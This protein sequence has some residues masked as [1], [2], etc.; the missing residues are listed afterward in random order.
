VVPPDQLQIIVSNIGITTDFSAIYTPNSAPHTAFVQVSLKVGHKVGSYEYMRRVRQQ[1]RQEL[2]QL[3]TYFQ[4]G[5]L[6]DAVINL[7]LPAPID[8]QVSGNNLDKVYEVATKIAGPVRALKSVNDVLIPQDIDYPALELDVDRQKAGLL[9]LSQKEIV[10]NVI[11]ALTSNGMIAPNYW[12]D[13]KSGNPYLLTVQYPEGAVK[14]MTDLKQIP[15]RG[16]KSTQPTSLDTVVKVKTIPSPTEVDHYQLFRVVDVYVSPKAED[17]GGITAQVEDVIKKTTLPEG[18]RVNLRGSVQGMRSSF[19][20]FGIGLILSIVLVY[21]VLVAQF[22]SWKDPFI[23]LLAI[24]PG[25]AGVLLFLLATG[26]TLNVMSLMGVV[27]MVG[28]VVSNSIL[29]VEFARHL[30]HDGKPVQE[31]VSLAS[32]MRLR[33]ILMTSF[34]TLLGMIPMAIGA[35]PGSE[36]YAPLA[37]A[38]IGG[39]LVSVV[40]TVYLVPAAYLLVHRKR[41]EALQ[42]VRS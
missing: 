25:L 33:P 19:K 15:L 4:S 41:E 30:H 40:V 6:V 28:I 31:A 7:G 22:A 9:G 23:I 36:Q 27:M 18:V 1:L 16:V 29:I 26:T 24:P 14:S 42:E 10:D 13:P 3:T 20:S 8:I 2:P 37:R 39:L 35:E 21:L 17:L 12:I 38:I 11:T 5:G 34:A 32:R